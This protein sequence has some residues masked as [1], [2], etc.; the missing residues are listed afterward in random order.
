MSARRNLGLIYSA[1]FLRSLG[2]GLVGV[3]LG[4]YLFRIG[5][6]SLQ[7]GLVIGAGLGGAALG[8]LII[9]RYGDRLGRRRTLFVLSILASLAGV[10]LALAS[11][12][13]ALL[14][15]AFLCMLN[16]MGTDRT[17]AFALEQAVIPELADE[18]R[19]TW[20]LSW[21]NLVLDIG[22]ALGA[23]S[24]TIPLALQHWMHSD[25]ASAYKLIFF[26]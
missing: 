8:L 26:G 13:A 25:L 18:K 10:G 16:G 21:Y 5:L 23:L 7:I 24:A 22:H 11:T 12:F 19:R 9:S 20:A 4:V 3:I 2:I 1:A 17:A 6:S 15:L 14:P